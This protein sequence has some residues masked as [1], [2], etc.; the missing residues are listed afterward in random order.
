MRDSRG[1]RECDHE[2]SNCVMSGE[3]VDKLLVFV[4]A[5]LRLSII[6]SGRGIFDLSECVETRRFL[7]TC[8]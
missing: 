8:V 7:Y 3:G 4:A 5:T 1:Y 2:I 6:A